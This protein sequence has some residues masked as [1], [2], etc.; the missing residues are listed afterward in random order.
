MFWL[1]FI[2]G[3]LAETVPLMGATAIVALAVPALK[4][5]TPPPSSFDPRGQSL[6][7]CFSLEMLTITRWFAPTVTRPVH[8]S[9]PYLVTVSS[10]LPGGTISSW[11]LIMS[12]LNSSTCPT[13][14]CGLLP[15]SRTAAS[16]TRLMPT[17]IWMRPR[18]PGTS[19]PTGSSLTSNGKV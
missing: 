9:L 1:Q 3:G 17:S 8:S 11:C 19:A 18:G 16:P 6:V 2:F 12:L 15:F 14:Y 7:T 10:C 4:R 5:C 13:K